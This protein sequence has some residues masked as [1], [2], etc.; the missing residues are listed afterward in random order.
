[1]LGLKV[2]YHHYLAYCFYSYFI[3]RC[4]RAN[5]GLWPGYQLKHWALFT[6]VCWCIFLVLNL[7]FVVLTMGFGDNELYIPSPCPRHVFVHPY[8]HQPTLVFFLEAW[9]LV[10]MYTVC[11]FEGWGLKVYTKYK[12]SFRYGSYSQGWDRRITSLTVAQIYTISSRL[13]LN[14][15][16]ASQQKIRD[17]TCEGAWISSISG[18]PSRETSLLISVERCLYLTIPQ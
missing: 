7:S 4:Q 12:D 13:C 9:V 8:P 6:T 15:K 17:F 14:S 18:V 16:T 3:L 2:V 5:L 1:M 11:R 10:Y